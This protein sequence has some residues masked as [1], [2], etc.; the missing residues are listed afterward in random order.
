M[1]TL[2]VELGVGGVPGS[3]RDVAVGAGEVTADRGAT[4]VVG[5][6]GTGL[7][8][9]GLDEEESDGIDPLQD[10]LYAWDEAKRL[11]AWSDLIERDAADTD[12]L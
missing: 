6:N 12:L 3:C 10:D 9:S 2:G 5:T 7:T 11:E 1:T 8:A 4:V